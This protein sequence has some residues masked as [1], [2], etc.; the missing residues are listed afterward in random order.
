MLVLTFLVLACPLPLSVC[1]SAHVSVCIRSVCLLLCT[2]IHL[3]C[4]AVVAFL[5]SSGT[6]LSAPTVCLLVCSRISL[7]QVCLSAALYR[8]PSCL[9]SCCCLSYLFWYKS[10]RSHCLSVGRLTYH[11]YL[12]TCCCLSSLCRACPLALSVC[13]SAQLSILPVKLLLP[14]LLGPSTKR[15]V[16][17]HC[18]SAVQLRYLSCLFC[19]FLS[20]LS[21]APSPAGLSFPAVCLLLC[22]GIHIAPV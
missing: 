9:S 17:S 16:L 10:V 20:Y 4:L 22:T 1:W 2:G 11:S 19:C 12:S 15:P 18:L 3:A 7:Y 21:W 6:S 13:W 5:I 8:Y 14:I